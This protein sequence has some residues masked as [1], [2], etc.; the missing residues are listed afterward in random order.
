MCAGYIDHL[1]NM[2][3]GELRAFVSSCLKLAQSVWNTNYRSSA[4]Y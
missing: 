3:E 4:K 2:V 1:N